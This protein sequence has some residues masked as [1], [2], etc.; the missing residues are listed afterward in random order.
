MPTRRFDRRV[1]LN[2]GLRKKLGLATLPTNQQVAD[3]TETNYPMALGEALHRADNPELHP[4]KEFLWHDV[5]NQPEN[6]IPMLQGN[7]F[8]AE[9]KTT[10]I[11]MYLRLNFPIGLIAGQ[12]F[13]NFYQQ[14]T[15]TFGHF[16]GETAQDLMADASPYTILALVSSFIIDIVK[17]PELNFSLFQAGQVTVAAARAF[18]QDLQEAQMIYDSVATELYQEKEKQA[19]FLSALTVSPENLETQ[20]HQTLELESFLPCRKRYKSGL[21]PNIAEKIFSRAGLRAAFKISLPEHEGYKTIVQEILAEADTDELEQL[22]AFIPQ[23]IQEKEVWIRDKKLTPRTANMIIKRNSLRKLLGL[24]KFETEYDEVKFEDMLKRSNNRD[25]KFLFAMLVYGIKERPTDLKAALAD[26]TIPAKFK[27]LLLTTYFT[28]LGQNDP[29]EVGAD[30]GML[31]ISHLP[32][33]PKNWAVIIGELT[34]DLFDVDQTYIYKTPDFVKFIISVLATLPLIQD[35][36]RALLLWLIERQITKEK[37]RIF[38]TVLKHL[39]KGIDAPAQKT[40]AV[41]EDKTPAPAFVSHMLKTMERRAAAAPEDTQAITPRQA[42]LDFILAL[43]LHKKF[44]PTS[45]ARIVIKVAN[46]LFEKDKDEAISFIY[47]VGT[48]LY[49]NQTEKYQAYLDKVAKEL[50]LES[51]DSIA[52]TIIAALDP[53]IPLGTLIVALAEQLKKYSLSLEST[54]K[55]TIQVIMAFCGIEGGHL[56]R[57]FLSQL[58]MELEDQN[59][60]FDGDIFRSDLET[61]LTHWLED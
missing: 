38:G 23:E 8:G 29:E 13:N 36:Q 53:E 7:E 1:L 26:K 50:G 30:L 52:K 9:D 56:A 58:T 49:E 40:A 57:T 43:L 47:E 48:N 17:Q 21:S 61:E 16:V 10:F 39:F 45:C 41:A 59:P 35:K 31:L 55:I 42:Q 5:Y 15:F 2:N 37:G 19:A 22:R 20:K 54:A 46:I 32:E 12:I 3:H 25:A 34:K 33:E 28:A 60:S 51:E 44:T 18:T 11:A 27:A 24:P 4:V 14:Q 6:I